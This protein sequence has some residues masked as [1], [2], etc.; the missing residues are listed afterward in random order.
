MDR[1]QWHIKALGDIWKMVQFTLD[2]N[3]PQQPLCCIIAF[4]ALKGQSSRSR[5]QKSVNWWRRF[6]PHIRR[7]CFNLHHVKTKMFRNSLPV[8]SCILGIERAKFKVEDAKI[9]KMAKTFSA[10]YTP[11]MLQLA[12]REDQNVPQQSPCCQLHFGPKVKVKDVVLV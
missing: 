10:T 4:L 8:V 7:K 3:V 6:R 9:G 5:T 12:S 11:Q 1:L 2:K